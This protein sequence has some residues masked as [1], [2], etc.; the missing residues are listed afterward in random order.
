MT[1]GMQ[2]NDRTSAFLQPRQTSHS[3]TGRRHRPGRWCHCFGTSV[4]KKMVP[5][6]FFASRLS[7]ATETKERKGHLPLLPT[8]A[9]WCFLSPF[10]FTSALR[11]RNLD[12]RWSLSDIPCSHPR[13]MLNPRLLKRKRP[14]SPVSAAT[15]RSAPSILISPAFF[16]A[17]SRS[18]VQ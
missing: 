11:R 13:C 17:G 9:D 8:R 12:R 5:L 18:R 14:F 3:G 15:I 7:E 16:P 1:D 6:L 4:T 10:A 2:T